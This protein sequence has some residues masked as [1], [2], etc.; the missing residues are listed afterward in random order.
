MHCMYVILI[1]VHIW[2][3]II[4]IFKLLTDITE[5]NFKTFKISIRFIR[6]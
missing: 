3:V 2:G 5:F 6:F 1:I 4:N